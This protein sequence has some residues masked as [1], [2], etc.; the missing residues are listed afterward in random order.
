M[1]TALTKTPAHKAPAVK[2][3]RSS[4]CFMELELEARANLRF[5]SRARHGVGA[6]LIRQ[7]AV[8]ERAAGAADVVVDAEHVQH[9]QA[10]LDALGRRQAERPAQS[11]I[12]AVV[13]AAL[14]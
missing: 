12:G 13:L 7:R 1:A 9:L 3:R 2:L 10:D 8:D 4:V 5:L 14:E 11:H 6:E